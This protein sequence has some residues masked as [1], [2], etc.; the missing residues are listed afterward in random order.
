MTHT[1]RIDWK[2][3]FAFHSLLFMCLG[4]FF[5]AIAFKGFMIPNRFLDGGVTGLS[6]LF[7]ELFHIDISILLI[8]LNLPFI[9]IG[10]HKIGK[11]FAI[12]TFMAIILLV[13]TIQFLH[14]EPITKDKVLIALFGGFFI[15]LGIGFVIKAG[16][17]I[18]GMEVIAD[19]TNKKWGFSTS[20]IVM[21]INSAIILTAAYSFG[22][23]VGMYSIL[24]YFTA[25]K[26]SDYIV[27]GFEEYT[28]MT[29]ISPK[30][31]E[32]KSCIVN[33]FDKAISVYKGERGYLPGNFE[34]KHDCDIIVTIITRLEIH[35]I[36]TAIMD[37]DPNAF[38]YI[39]SI[40]EVKGGIIKQKIRR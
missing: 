32:I 1:D 19:Y 8:V 25:M 4:V 27:D 13:I 18:D 33:D 30:F 7:H 14:I 31:E 15:G 9:Y 40:K 38:L 37:I 34:I 20:E 29:I 6:I 16:G 24:T 35:R 21:F 23:E 10:Y 22:L 39:S 2:R 12:Q 28:A 26:T 11:T 5:A 17:V 3:I 36:K